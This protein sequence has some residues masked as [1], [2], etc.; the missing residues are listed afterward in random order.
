MSGLPVPQA[1]DFGLPPGALAWDLGYT[2]QSS[3]CVTSVIYI[4][5]IFSSL[6]VY[7]EVT[8][9]QPLC[10]FAIS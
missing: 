8:Y 6:Q 7:P 1:P 10:I 4:Y 3:I 5:I 9:L 2:T